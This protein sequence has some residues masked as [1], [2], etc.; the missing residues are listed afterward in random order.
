V[1]IEEEDIWK[2]V[3][4]TKQGIYKVLVLLLGLCNAL[5]NFIR[6]MNEILH[7]FID[8]LVVYFNDIILLSKTW[9]ERIQHLKKVFEIVQKNGLLLNLKKC[10]FSWQ[11]LFILDSLWVMVN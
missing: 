5:T 3:F 2:I 11:H 7:P 6:L 10:E 8:S 1:W 9:E 4:K